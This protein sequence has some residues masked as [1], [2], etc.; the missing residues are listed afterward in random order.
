MAEV[1]HQKN[2]ESVGLK[3]RPTKV[4][5]FG[6]PKIGT[7]LMKSAP[8]AG[9]DLPQKILVWESAAGTVQISYNY[10]EFLQTRDQIRDRN[11]EIQQIKSAMEK[12]ATAAAN[13]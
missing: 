5:F 8:T 13:S 11:N 12:L 1:G 6:N 10:P 3:L 9:L 4:I 2:A 7:P